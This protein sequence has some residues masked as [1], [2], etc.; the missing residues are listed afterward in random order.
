MEIRWFPDAL[1]DLDAIF[2][3]IHAAAPNAAEEIVSEI[4]STTNLLRENPKL[5]RSGRWP[6]TRELVVP[7][8]V[9]VYQQDEAAVAILAVHHSAR[10]WPDDMPELIGN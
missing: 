4:I 10:R 8:Y 7:P 9:V 1:A 3:Y 6:R 5:G 2:A